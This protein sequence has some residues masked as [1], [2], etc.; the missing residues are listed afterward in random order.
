MEP[1]FRNIERV[2][3]DQL[4]ARHRGVEV[5]AARDGFVML[6]LYQKQGTDGFFWGRGIGP[7]ALRASEALRQLRAERWLLRL[8]GIK[9]DVDCS[10]R[11]YVDRAVAKM[12]PL[13]VLRMLGYRRIRE[14][15]AHVTFE[16]QPD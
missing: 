8:P 7:A 9:R 10:R 2:R 1:G 12:V 6:P 16:R 5:R 14:R 3:R 15:D 4:L 11:L 13:G